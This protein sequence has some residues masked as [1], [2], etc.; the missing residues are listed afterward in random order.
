MT[1]GRK[2]LAIWLL[3]EMKEEKWVGKA[4]I[5]LNA[6]VNDLTPKRLEFKGRKKL[7]LSSVPS[8][9]PASSNLI[10]LNQC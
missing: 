7:R 3:V 8:D 2:A 9:L 6:E 10:I 4:P 5:L 1:L